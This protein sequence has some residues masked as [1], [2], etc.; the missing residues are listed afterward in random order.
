LIRSRNPQLTARQVMQR[1]ED[2][3][4]RP[5][6]G[7]DSQVGHGV[8]DALAAISAD[9]PGTSRSA[10]ATT[11]S[12]PPPSEVHRSDPLSRRVAFGGAAICV[13][14][15]AVASVSAGRLRRRRQPVAHD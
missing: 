13:A 8:V 12:M 11:R 15:A 9:G 5:A 4:H 3:A 14:V 7:W 10:P 1:I 6:A 2:T